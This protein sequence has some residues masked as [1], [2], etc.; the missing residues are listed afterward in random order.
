VAGLSLVW[1]GRKP[2]HRAT[3]ELGTSLHAYIEFNLGSVWH[4]SARQSQ[5][6]ATSGYELTSRE[7][8]VI[9]VVC[10]GYTN[11]EIARHLNIG[12][13]TVKTHLIHVFKKLGV[14]TR[15]ELISRILAAGSH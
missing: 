10:R 5:D 4:E 6:C 9:D 12:L 8:E 11:P 14:E 7:M 2:D 1:R 15:G 3:T 13:A